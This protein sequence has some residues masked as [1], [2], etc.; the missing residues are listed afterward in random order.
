[1]DENIKEALTSKENS[2][3]DISLDHNL[4]NNVLSRENTNDSIT[5]PSP[6]FLNQLN[7]IGD[8]PKQYDDVAVQVRDFNRFKK[9][10]CY[11]LLAINQFLQVSMI[12]G[13]QTKL[14]S[15]VHKVKVD[16]LP[17]KV[18]KEDLQLPTNL[19]EQIDMLKQGQDILCG[20]LLNSSGSID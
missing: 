20:I 14:A 2:F 18:D 8:L 17:R 11:I 19:V 10:C 13:L 12:S 6:E 1:V 7:R 5:E 4:D 15:D 16:I 3:D 9:A